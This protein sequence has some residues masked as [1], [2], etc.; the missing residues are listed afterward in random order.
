MD[1]SHW[2]GRHLIIG[3]MHGKESVLGPLLEENFGLKFSTL[4]EFD[5][6]QFGTF[7]GEKDR[8]GSPLEV[9]RMKCL[10]A[11]EICSVDLGLASEGSFGP[12]PEM[13][14]IALNEEYLVLID[15]KNQWEIV[16]KKSS[17]DTNLAGQI[18]DTEEELLSFSGSVGFPEHGIILKAE[19]FNEKILVKGICDHEHLIEEFRKLKGLGH[20]IL[21]E[22]DMRAMFNPKRMAVIEEA[23]KEL[24]KR[25]KSQCTQC[26]TPG[27]GPVNAH[28][29]LPCKGC[30]FRTASILYLTRMCA[31]CGYSDQLYYPNDVRFEDPQYCNFC[32]P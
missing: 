3:T 15:Q 21:A 12:H 17:F 7:S 26:K 5:T 14:F 6:D 32:N 19:S 28:P 24:V 23:G 13:G 25:M 16:V 20:S 11:M 18:I 10:A 22:T 8:I 30:G 1:M 27:F 29:G 31:G 4:T 9:A 2:K